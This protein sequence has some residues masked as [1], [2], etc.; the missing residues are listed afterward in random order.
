MQS[1][2]DGGARII[3]CTMTMDLL[4]M[5]PSDLMDGVE[6]GGV[7]SLLGEAAESHTTLFI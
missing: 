4:G 1:A 7:A 5:A 3:A 6:Y 2:K